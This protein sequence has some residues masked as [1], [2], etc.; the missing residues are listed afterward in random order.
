MPANSQMYELEERGQGKFRHLEGVP[1]RM[2]R[3]VRRPA[4]HMPVLGK[5]SV[6]EPLGHL[7]SYLV[8]GNPRRRHSTMP[9]RRFTTFVNPLSMRILAATVL[10]LPVRQ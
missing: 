5:S 10:R 3:G 7:T 2:P 6:C 9:L 4:G 1:V 8:T